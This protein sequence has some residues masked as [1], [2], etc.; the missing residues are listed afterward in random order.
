VDSNCAG[1]SNEAEWFHRPVDCERPGSIELSLLV[2]PPPRTESQNEKKRPVYF[3][4]MIVDCCI[5]F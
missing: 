4:A 1:V 3:F 5:Y 2:T